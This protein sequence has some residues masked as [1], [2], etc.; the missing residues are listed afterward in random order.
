[1]VSIAPEYRDWLEAHAP[2]MHY[3]AM[4]P[5][6]LPGP[7]VEEAKARGET[8]AYRSPNLIFLPREELAPSRFPL[9]SREGGSAQ[10]F[11]VGTSH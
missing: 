10:T 8:L 4:F 5:N 11:T 3:R 2:E 7:L 1:V 9:R 6:V